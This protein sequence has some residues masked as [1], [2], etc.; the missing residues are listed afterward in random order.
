MEL[1]IIFIS[2]A[3]VNN[4]VLANFLGICPSLEFQTKHHRQFLWDW[5]QRLLW[6]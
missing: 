6:C 4:F 2:A 3:L 5:R 1:L